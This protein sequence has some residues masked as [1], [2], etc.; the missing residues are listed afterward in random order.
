MYAFYES[1]KLDMSQQFD[2][3]PVR[4]RKQNSIEDRASQNIN[5]MQASN[6]TDESISFG[7]TASHLP[8]NTGN[9]E[10]ATQVSQKCHGESFTGCVL[11]SAEY[12][13]KIFF[14]EEA[15]L[16][17]KHS[18][19]NAFNLHKDFD[20]TF[21]LSFLDTTETHSRH[22]KKPYKNDDV[23]E[24]EVVETVLKLSSTFKRRKKRTE[25]NKMYNK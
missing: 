15:V 21:A 6:G 11:N 1:L 10:D 2:L 7:L 9:V 16:F 18:A 22:D 4:I 14:S 17:S 3:L 12:F 19:N 13:A 23:D 8:K 25:H 20:D 5:S 24:C